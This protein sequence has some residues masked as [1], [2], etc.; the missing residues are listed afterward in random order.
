[1]TRTASGGAAIIVSALLCFGTAFSAAAET[2]VP[3]PTP[4]PSITSVPV[5]VVIPSIPS[6]PAPT[7]SSSSTRTPGTTSGGS[8][9]SPAS[10]PEQDLPTEAVDAPVPPAEPT[11]DSAGL[12]ID[13][14]S[15]VAYEWMVATGTGFEP[16]EKV[17][18][19]FYPGAVVIGSYP[20]DQSG[21]VVARL[22]VPSDIRPGDHVVEAT[23][24]TSERVQNAEFL[25]VTAAAGGIPFLW[26]LFVVA[27]VLLVGA[28]TTA[29]YFRHTIAGWFGGGLRASGV[30]P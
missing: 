6:S 20:A 12:K 13:K 23:G 4:T 17:Q 1:M 14:E 7:P 24:W 2:E 29:I 3:T 25:V 19:V 11:A 5:T 15:Y 27:G 18:F 16:G 10:D 22:R 28:I 30:S 8:S 9:S 26:W 21:T